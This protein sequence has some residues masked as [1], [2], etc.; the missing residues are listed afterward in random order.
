MSYVVGVV[1]PRG[2]RAPAGRTARL[3]SNNLCLVLHLLCGLLAH[4][5]THTK[6][7]AL[8]FS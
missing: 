7:S 5:R 1:V 2:E 3:G 4:T 6:L 8:P